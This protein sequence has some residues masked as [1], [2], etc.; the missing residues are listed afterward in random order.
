VRTVAGAGNVHENLWGFLG[1]G[2]GRGGLGVFFVAVGDR[3]G[4]KEELG[5]VGQRGGLAARDAAEG[6]LFEE[7]AEEEIHAGGGGEGIGAG[8]EF[9]AGALPVRALER[10][11]CGA[12]VM[13]AEG[14]V[15]R[16]AEH[17]A[18]AV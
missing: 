11:G 5:D 3:D 12:S 4:V 8:E 14:R 6:G 17:F 13:G 7:I 16:C 10:L 15:V 1:V 18:A 9:D 2:L